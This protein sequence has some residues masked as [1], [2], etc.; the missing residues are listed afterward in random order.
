M[1]LVE[2]HHKEDFVT[3]KQAAE[4]AKQQ[5]ICKAFPHN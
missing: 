2:A 1:K 3:Q 4:A 5:R